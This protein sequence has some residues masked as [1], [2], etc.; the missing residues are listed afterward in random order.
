MKKTTILHIA[1]IENNPCNGVCVAVPQHILSQSKF[2]EVGLI[3]VNHEKIMI[4]ARHQIFLHGKFDID[5]IPA[6]YNHPD[7]VIFHETYY[8]EYLSIYKILI[9]KN[10]PYIILPHGCLTQT[11]QH[12]KYWK[13]KIGNVLFF[14]KFINHAAALQC[15]SQRELAE[16]KYKIK[17][18]IGTNGIAMPKKTK[19]SFHTNKTQFVYIGRLDAYHKGIDL[20]IEAVAKSKDFLVANRCYFSLYGPD[21]KGRYAHVQKLIKT[22]KVEKLIRLSPA[23]YGKEKEKILLDA[24]VFIQTS[25][26]EGMP[27]GILE[28][29]SYGLPVLITEG[30]TLGE[31]VKKSNAGWVAKTNAESITMQIGKVI[32]QR[33]EWQQK[34]QNAVKMTEENFQWN[35]ISKK[36]AEKYQQ[37]LNKEQL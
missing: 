21:Y 18:F 16:T 31:F 28:A 15:L 11:A 5:T 17:K 30:T 33:A 37:A 9:Q 6:P 8:K 26:F 20:L 25:R 12:K 23:V 10:I 14:N 27:M 2:A 32:K 24:D 34:S 1:K 3:N 13:K 29:L 7:L 36:T 4:L 22:H 35:A 19:A